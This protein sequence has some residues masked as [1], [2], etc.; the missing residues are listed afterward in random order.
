LD[1]KA[2]NLVQANSTE[3]RN[4]CARNA[5]KVVRR[6]TISNVYVLELRFAVAVF[7][8]SGVI[9]R[10]KASTSNHRLRDWVIE[11]HNPI[12]GPTAEPAADR[13]CRRMIQ[14][15]RAP[16]T[17]SPAFAGSF[18]N[19]GLHSKPYLRK[20]TCAFRPT[21]TSSCG[22]PE[23]TRRPTGAARICFA[24]R[25]TRLPE[26]SCEYAAAGADSR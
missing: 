6:T 17:C 15:E 24:P 19:T 18:I 20:G 4:T 2:F 3:W 14:R 22:R 23:D 12:I 7:S 8:L 1:V 26:G 21:W 5:S 11:S 25:R 10:A 9:Q 16:R 13:G